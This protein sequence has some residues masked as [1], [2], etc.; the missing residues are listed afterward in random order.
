MQKLAAIRQSA[1]GNQQ[2]ENI[3]IAIYLN[4]ANN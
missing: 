4:K 2:K 1:I 3:L